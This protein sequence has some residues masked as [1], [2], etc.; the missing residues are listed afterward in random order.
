MGFTLRNN[1]HN[2]NNNNNNNN[3]M[4]FG[5]SIKYDAHIIFDYNAQNLA[6]ILMETS[7]FITTPSF[8]ALHN[9][10]IKTFKF[11]IILSLPFSFKREMSVSPFLFFFM[12]F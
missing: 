3:K 10:L 12:A 2:N 8:V 7:T 4:G 9:F 6:R 1:N 11:N 5:F